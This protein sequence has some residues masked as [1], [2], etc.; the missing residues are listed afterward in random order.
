M[1]EIFRFF[2]ENSRHLMEN[3]YNNLKK[4]VYNYENIPDGPIFN[5]Y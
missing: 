1:K 5:S 4:G 2:I 3:G